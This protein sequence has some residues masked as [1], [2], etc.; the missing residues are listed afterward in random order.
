MSKK[1]KFI[2]F[3]LLM[4]IFFSHEHDVESQ[5]NKEIIIA[6]NPNPDERFFPIFLNYGT[7]FKMMDWNFRG[8]CLGFAEAIC[9]A[10][11]YNLNIRE[12]DIYVVKAWINNRQND[13]WRLLSDIIGNLTVD[14]NYYVNDNF[15]VIKEWL[16]QDRFVPI[17]LLTGDAPN[18]GHAGVAYAITRS[19]INNRYFIYYYDPNIGYESKETIIL[20]ENHNEI[21]Y[22]AKPY[23]RFF[24]IQ[25]YKPRF[26]A[27]GEDWVVIQKFK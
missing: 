4:I 21:L 12:T 6:G 13:L 7:D 24:A 9:D 17:A 14:P 22:I 8:H 20:N 16:E 3:I 26:P 11:A 25:K 1:S 18:I 19:L 5:L 2:V 10:K 27:N 15:N 23:K